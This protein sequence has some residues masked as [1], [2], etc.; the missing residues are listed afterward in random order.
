MKKFLLL[1]CIA[2]ASCSGTPEKQISGVPQ[3]KVD[4][5]WPKP[6]P[7]TWMLGQVAGVAVDRNDNVWIVHRPGTLLDVADGNGNLS[8][9]SKGS[10]YTT[11]VGSGRRVQRF[12]KQ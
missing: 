6:L 4:P 10:I 12:V 8:I 3:Y 11:E 7:G 1:A 2:L 5:Y 9:D